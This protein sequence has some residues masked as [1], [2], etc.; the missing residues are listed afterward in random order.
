[1]FGLFSAVCPLGTNE[2]VWVERRMRWF[3]DQFGIERMRNARV[4][5]PTDEFCPDPYEADFVSARNS[6]D[7][8]C[9]YMGIDP[10]TI[11]LEVLEDDQMIGAVGLYEMREQSNICIAMSQ[12]GYPDQLMASNPSV[13]GSGGLG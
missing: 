6:L 1:M 13:S 8:M 9:V 10:A 4:I 5:L 2:K 12:L 3:A 11:T 7:R